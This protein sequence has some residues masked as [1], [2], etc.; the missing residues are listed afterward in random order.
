MEGVL[1]MFEKNHSINLTPRRQGAK[2]DASGLS[3][4]STRR[5]SL[6]LCAL[7]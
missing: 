6:R 2:E 7:A 5:I 4:E 3:V 1:L